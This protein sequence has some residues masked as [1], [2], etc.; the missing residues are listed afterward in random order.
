MG[1]R[2]GILTFSSVFPVSDGTDGLLLDSDGDLLTPTVR[3]L[4]E[5]DREDAVVEGGTRLARV[6]LLG[7]VHH[8]AEL[9][10]GALHAVELGLRRR[11]DRGLVA[12]DDERIALRRHL[13]ILE[14]DA[15]DLALHNE[16]IFALA[17]IDVGQP[18]LS[19]V[20][21]GALCLE[22]DVEELVHLA[23]NAGDLE[24]MAEVPVHV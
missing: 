15:R 5:E 1:S 6:D 22:D 4:R 21:F 13:E 19:A 14:A 24:E 11:A 16:A 10:V 18:P 23:L 17:D 2:S 20:P 12:R 8:A 3:D 9:P 7:E